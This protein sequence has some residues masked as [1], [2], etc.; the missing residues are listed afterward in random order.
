MIA[1]AALPPLAD[2]LG[3]LLPDAQDTLLLRA[4]LGDAA[5]AAAAWDAWLAM[6]KGMPKALAERPRSRR[7]LPLL[8][9]ALSVHGIALTEPALSI[10]RA[11]TLWEERRA[12]RIQAILIEVLASLRRTGIAVVLLKGAALAETA[13]PQFRLRHCHD[14]D[15]LV[16]EAAL[17]QAG[18]ALI[19]AGFLPA[20]AARE[21]TVGQS[22]AMKHE[23]GLPVNLH[24]SLW[25]TNARGDPQ[26]SMLRRAR[27]IDIGGERAT[28]LAPTDMLLHVCGHA[29]IGAGPGNWAWIADAAMIQRRH[30]LTAEDWAGLVRIAA[31]IGIA[32]PLA[33]RFG[34]LASRIGLPIPPTALNAL[35]G[36]ACRSS[37]SERDAAISA[38]RAASGVPFIA[39]LRRSG[40][41]SRMDLACWALRRSPRFVRTR[42]AR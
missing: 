27:F 28:I 5:S 33:A 37:R 38:T 31:E 10:L 36:A 21:R 26:A 40:W 9:H 32:L 2:T 18:Q 23:D 24:T 8:H 12:T 13:Y 29:G 14:L 6:A 20:A 11:A 1:R 25:T 42:L 19:A 15:L 4:C 17:P 22:L 41:R 16:E 3:W 39:M 30:E 35:T 7:F 34:Y